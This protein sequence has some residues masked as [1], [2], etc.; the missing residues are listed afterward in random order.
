MDEKEFIDTFLDKL[1]LYGDKNTEDGIYSIS[2]TE[3][4]EAAKDL[5][6]ELIKK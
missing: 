2:Q 1:Y 6:S 4:I 3:A 5:Y